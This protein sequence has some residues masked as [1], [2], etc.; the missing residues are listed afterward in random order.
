MTS[1]KLC[2]K[3]HRDLLR[4]RMKI[5]SDVGSV[6]PDPEGII[7]QDRWSSENLRQLAHSVWAILKAFCCPFFKKPSMHWFRRP[8]RYSE[9]VEVR[10][11]TRPQ[12]SKLGEISGNKIFF[13]KKQDFLHKFAQKGT[14]FWRGPPLRSQKFLA[15]CRKVI[16]ATT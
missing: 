8:F 9:D 11:K 3:A 12:T 13:C 4:R 5:F 6:V 16:S 2:Q 14:I 10:R 7:D 15:S 1:S